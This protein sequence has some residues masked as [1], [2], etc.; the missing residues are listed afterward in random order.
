MRACPTIAS[1]LLLAACSATPDTGSVG[2]T[3]PSN[4]TEA[5]P[6]PDPGVDC[7]TACPADGF[8]L[9]GNDN[10]SNDRFGSVQAEQ[11]GDCSSTHP[12]N[13]PGYYELSAG[14]TCTIS[15]PDAA[16]A[17]ALSCVR[18]ACGE[19]GQFTASACI[20]P[21]AGTP[22]WTGHCATREEACSLA[23]EANGQ[24]LA[25]VPDATQHLCK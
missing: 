24:R 6:A 3:D 16:P 8:A 9:V 14:A 20:G 18:F 10:Y 22:N 15:A 13:D 7:R 12:S 4:L 5:L 23:Y 25:G 1:L 11:Y 17:G 2:T 19:T 21:A